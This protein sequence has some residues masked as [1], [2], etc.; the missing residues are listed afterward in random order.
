[1][2]GWVGDRV[3][4]GGVEGEWLEREESKGGMVLSVA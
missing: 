4:R 3:E 1:V 2:V